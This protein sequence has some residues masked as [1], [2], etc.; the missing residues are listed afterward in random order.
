M[1]HTPKNVFISYS[2]DSEQHRQWVLDLANQLRESHVNAM[3][4]IFFTQISTVNLN[5]MM[6]SNMRD[7]DRIIV[8]LTE[9][10]ALKAE[11]LKGGVGFETILTVSEMQENIDKYI[12][13]VRHKGDLNKAIPFHLKGYYFIDF[14]ND[15]NF[16]ANFKQLL[17]KIYEVPQIE[18]ARLGTRPNLIP[19]KNIESEKVESYKHQEEVTETILTEVKSQLSSTFKKMEKSQKNFKIDFKDYSDKKYEFLI[20]INNKIHTNLYLEKESDDKIYFSTSN[21]H[22]H[23]SAVIDF[24]MEI[25]IRK[26]N[27]NEYKAMIFKNSSGNWEEISSKGIAESFWERW[28]TSNFPKL[29]ANTK[30]TLDSTINLEAFYSNQKDYKLNVMYNFI[31]GTLEEEFTGNNDVLVF[32]EKKEVICKFTSDYRGEICS[33]VND[34][35]DPNGKYT[36]EIGNNLSTGVEN[37]DCEFGAMYSLN[38]EISYHLNNDK[39]YFLSIR[40]LV[41]DL[42]TEYPQL[43]N[44]YNLSEEKILKLILTNDEETP[45]PI[46]QCFVKG[47]YYPYQSLKADIMLTD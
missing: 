18:M 35:L 40:E 32:N 4:D 28:Y 22:A 27:K 2:W 46:Y 26:N 23:Y 24:M 44:K 36:I 20:Y 45:V 47:D 7:S 42:I 5:T 12:F 34:W 10:Y 43:T 14:S 31:K 30:T 15:N 19:S 29:R 38:E 37:L 3:I 21:R 25:R 41:N 11:N 13:I 6:I 1:E 16:E 33:F 8:V 17:H 9:D 39:Q